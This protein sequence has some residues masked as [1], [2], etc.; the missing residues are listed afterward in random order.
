[1]MDAG[2][3]NPDGDFRFD[4]SLGPGYIFNL[5][6]KG[7]AHGTYQLRIGVSNDPNPLFVTFQVN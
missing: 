4:A 6:T 5:K 3:S 2:N 7:L 1:V